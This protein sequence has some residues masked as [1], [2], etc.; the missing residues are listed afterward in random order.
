L[1]LAV[2]RFSSISFKTPLLL[3]FFLLQTKLRQ[4]WER[5]TRLAWGEESANLAAAKTTLATA[6]VVIFSSHNTA[7]QV[8]LVLIPRF[9]PFIPSNLDPK[10]SPSV[11]GFVRMVAIYSGA[12]IPISDNR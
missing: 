4:A 3:G 2:N 7:F 1:V 12:V 10:C 6:S 8:L 11:L 9:V 5:N